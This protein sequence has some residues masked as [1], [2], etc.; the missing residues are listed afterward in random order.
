MRARFADAQ[1][2]ALHLV[3]QRIH[4]AFIII[5]PPDD[6]RAGGNH[7]PQQEFFLHDVEIVG[8]IRRARHGILKLRQISNAADL[9]QKLFIFEAL[10]NGDDVNGHPFVEHGRQHF[11]NRLVPQVVEN[12]LAAVLELFDAF[13]HAFVWRKQRATQ[14]ALLGLRRMRRQPVNGGAGVLP[15][16]LLPARFF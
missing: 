8:E 9:F 2:I 13:A 1:N 16:R 15:S 7:F 12:F 11:V 10:L 14:H 6:V 5:N 3:H 4:L